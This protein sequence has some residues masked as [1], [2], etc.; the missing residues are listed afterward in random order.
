[1]KKPARGLFITGTNTEIG[2]S[3]V[4][5]MIARQLHEQGRRVGVYKPAASGCTGPIDDLFSEDADQLWQAAGQPLT[6]NAVCPQRFQAPLAPHVA[7]EK[8]GA[9]IDADKLVTGLSVWANA[10]D[11]VIVEGVGGLMSPV[12][13]DDYVADLAWDFGYPLIVVAANELGVINQT[14]QTL[15]TAETFRGGLPVAGLIVNHPRGESDESAATNV[16]ELRTRCVPPL[17]A[18]VNYQQ[19]SFT[20]TIDWWDLAEPVC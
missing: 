12:S 9:T 16:A 13:T 7:A 5:A 15:I 18:E 8:Q 14:L 4:A 19:E 11:I 17:L 1:M 20:E 6:L 3:W 2:K 10:C